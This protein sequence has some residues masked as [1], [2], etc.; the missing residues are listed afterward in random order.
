VFDEDAKWCWEN[1]KT[2]SEFIMEYV[3]A[4]QSE[5]VI[6]CHEEQ[7]ASPVPGAGEVASPMVSHHT[8]I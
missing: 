1:D 5:V 6:T 7:A 3:Q 8:Q 4:D 2:N